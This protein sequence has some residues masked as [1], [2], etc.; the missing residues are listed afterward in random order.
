MVSPSFSRYVLFLMVLAR[1]TLCVTCFGGQ[2]QLSRRSWV[3]KAIAA[4]SLLIAVPAVA[5]AIMEDCLAECVKECQFL[6]PGSVNEPYCRSTCE[7][8][9][10]NKDSAGEPRGKNDVVRQDL[11]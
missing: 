1:L 10:K 8:Y 4:P 9:C 2:R 11:S 3:S 5:N 7:D 6:A